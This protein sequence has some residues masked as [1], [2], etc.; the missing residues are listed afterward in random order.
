MSDSDSGYSAIINN[1]NH[2]SN[3][4][5]PVCSPTPSGEEEQQQRQR[6]LQA[7]GGDRRP[8]NY[9]QLSSKD[10]PDDV[11]I[12]D[13]SIRMLRSLPTFIQ[14]NNKPLMRVVCTSK[15]LHKNENGDLVINFKKIRDRVLARFTKSD[16][17]RRTKQQPKKGDDSSNNNNGGDNN[18]NNNN[19]NILL[20]DLSSGSVDDSN[21]DIDSILS[22]LTPAEHGQ[23]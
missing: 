12:A 21:I 13:I 17:R 14:D 2:N 15:L 23:Y 3:S 4:S 19:N 6:Q 5:S 22:P 16:Q 11:F 8:T 7:A 20:L 10:L 9:H 18:N 1:S